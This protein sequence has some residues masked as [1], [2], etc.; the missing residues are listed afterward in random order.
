MTSITW[1]PKAHSQHALGPIHRPHAVPLQGLGLVWLFWRTGCERL[2]IHENALGWFDEAAKHFYCK[3]KYLFTVG[4]KEA[5]L[6]E[7]M[8]R[9]GRLTRLK[10]KKKMIYNKS[11]ILPDD[12]RL[13][14]WNV[15]TPEFWTLDHVVILLAARGRSSEK[16]NA[17][18]ASNDLASIWGWKP[19]LRCFHFARRLHKGASVRN[20]CAS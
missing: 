16:I 3:E 7:V 11:Q 10:W 15:G 17:L 4:K 18:D 6:A 5:G 13:R 14:F 8:G 19:R 1:C 2:V 20:L 9:C 12:P